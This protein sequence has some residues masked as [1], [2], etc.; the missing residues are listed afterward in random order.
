M[1]LPISNAYN[2]ILLQCQKQPALPPHPEEV[3]IMERH[4]NES[5]IYIRSLDER[6]ITTEV[7]KP[8]WATHLKQRSVSYTGAPTYLKYFIPID[9]KQYGELVEKLF[10]LITL[11]YRCYENSN[12][13]LRMMS[14]TSIVKLFEHICKYTAE[15]IECEIKRLR[16]E[17]YIKRY[18]IQRGYSYDEHY[19]IHRGICHGEMK[20]R[21]KMALET[22][23][24]WTI[25]YKGTYKGMR[26]AY[27]PMTDTA[28]AKSYAAIEK[29][30]PWCGKTGRGREW[31]QRIQGL[32]KWFENQNMQTNFYKVKTTNRNNR[33]GKEY[34]WVLD[35][36]K[37]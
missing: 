9:N 10:K 6:L 20:L 37:I 2:Y 4:A 3:D 13:E 24:D 8:G 7:Y 14:F 25:A 26:V 12:S 32:Q 19:E 17:R 29:I 27:E 18:E 35:E 5:G 31:F 28:R 22:V 11:E 30:A 36:M 23:F 21:L 16:N 34:M 33:T 1:S 15:Q